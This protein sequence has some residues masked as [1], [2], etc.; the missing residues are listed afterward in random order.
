MNKIILLLSVLIIGMTGWAQTYQVYA[1]KGEV[2]CGQGQNVTPVSVGMAIDATIY[3]SISKGG[4]LVVLNEFQKEL[5][6][7]KNAASGPI[8]DLVKKEENS[9][10]QLTDSYLTYIKEKMKDDG[11][12]KDRNYRQAVASSYRDPDSLLLE[13]L[14]HDKEIDSIRKNT[15]GNYNNK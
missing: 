14:F 15:I 10:Q 9:V 6:T 11:S 3:I 12:P 2:T 1:V 5:C 8:A 13:S 7:I 4:R